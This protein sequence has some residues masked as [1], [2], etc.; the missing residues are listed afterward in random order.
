[1]AAKKAKKVSNVGKV[2]KRRQAPKPKNALEANQT[3]TIAITR[4]TRHKLH[5][6]KNGLIKRTG[7]MQTLDSTIW[8]LIKLATKRAKQRKGK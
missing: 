7:E 3:A 4:G 5:Q 6:I 2:L 8:W 1:M